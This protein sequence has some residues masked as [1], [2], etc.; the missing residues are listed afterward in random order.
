[1]PGFSTFTV[2]YK[3]SPWKNQANIKFKEKTTSFSESAQKSDPKKLGGEKICP[4][5]VFLDPPPI[6]ISYFGGIKMSQIGLKITIFVRNGG[7]T[8]IICHQTNFA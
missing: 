6:L 4:K 7:P 3:K 2:S 1:M 8:S 5:K